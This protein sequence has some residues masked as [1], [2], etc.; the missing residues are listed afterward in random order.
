VALPLLLLSVFA[1]VGLVCLSGRPLMSVAAMLVAAAAVAGCFYR[2]WSLL[3]L[4]YLAMIGGC[5][6][7][8]V[9]Y[10]FGYALA[11]GLIMAALFGLAVLC[12]LIAG[13][14]G[15]IQRPFHGNGRYVSLFVIFFV[16]WTALSYFTAVDR[17]TSLRATI[18]LPLVM[19]WG[20]WVVPASLTNTRHVKAVLRFIVYIAA[21][22]VIFNTLTAIRPVE[23]GG[24]RVGWWGK[25][26]WE[27]KQRAASEEE[28]EAFGATRRYP[29]AF[30]GHP[31]AMASFLAICIV[32]T[33]YFIVTGTDRRSRLLLALLMAGIVIYLLLTGSRNSAGAAIVAA[34]AFTYLYSRRAFLYTF[35]VIVLLAAVVVGS[36]YVVVYEYGLPISAHYLVI[37]FLKADVTS[38]RLEI[39]QGAAE[40]MAKRPWFGLGIN[41]AHLVRRRNLLVAGF[42]TAHNAYIRLAEETGLCTALWMLAYMGLLLGTAWRMHVRKIGGRLLGAAFFATF[43]G[44]FAHQ[45][46]DVYMVP[47]MNQTPSGIAL[48][49]LAGALLKL[50]ELADDDEAEATPHTQDE[51]EVA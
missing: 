37:K 50:P 46:F 25:A 40:N 49:F 6:R 35:L 29:V 18:A 34:M 10:R 8:A 15:H 32:P 33:L 30:F 17:N 36:V 7:A 12:W 5:L 48:V 21:F 31:S 1:V 3:D 23:Y 24:F 45:M 16:G 19:L 47:S 42:S 4:C 20:H 26:D 41:G 13:W 27:G 28:L 51:V 44:I 39:W 22:V 43:A 11:G 9:S 2:R 14:H 38:G